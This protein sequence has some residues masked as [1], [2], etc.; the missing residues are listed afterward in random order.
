[1]IG[2]GA[3]RHS[4]RAA[5]LVLGDLSLAWGALAAAVT[6]RRTVP[7]P[8][9]RSLLTAG[10][11]S[12]DL[13][14]ALLFGPAFVIALAL[15][16]F[17][18]RRILSRG[19]PLLIVALLIQVALVAVAAALF[20]A[21]LPRTILFAVPLAEALIFPLWR[22]AQLRLWPVRPQDT[23]LVGEPPE[24]AAALA[25]LEMTNDRRIHVIGYAGSRPDEV[26]ERWLG[27]L[28]EPAVRAAVRDVPEVISVSW[29]RGTHGRLELLR[30]RGPRG[31]LLL[32]SPAD[33]LLTSSVPGG[34]GDE[35]LIEVMIG[36][37]F[38]LRARVKRFVD[39]V[40][41]MILIVLT[42]PLWAA[43]AMSLLLDDGGPVL[44]RQMR[45]GLGCVPFA[46]WKFRSMRAQAAA[47]GESDDQRITPIGQFL[48]RYHIDELPQLLNVI[49]GDMSLVGPRPERPHI[50]ERILEEIPD[51]D[52]RCLVRPGMAG[53]AQVLAEYDSRPAVKL[54]YDITYMCS[55]S[56]WLDFRLIFSS[57]AAALSGTGV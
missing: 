1:M 22:S 10:S 41:S 44:L 43:V 42:L 49:A 39:V 12:A 34:M 6:I 16:G 33:A 25:V 51:F 19:R 30:I 18:R 15:A 32:A 35:P 40:A 24:I 54:R 47:T 53:L 48:R 50:A 57:V 52:L 46:M 20:Q 8:F 2:P 56:L 36:C 37:G 13:A 11:L 17:Y 45:L 5:I 27:Q 31:F 23:I 14:I 55:W 7:L 4:L 26:K 3:R 38:G 9:T 29:E 21:R 28:D